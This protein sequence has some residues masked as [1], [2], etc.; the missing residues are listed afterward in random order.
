MSQEITIRVH[1]AMGIVP[2]SAKQSWEEYLRNAPPLQQL[3]TYEWYDSWARTCGTC[4]PWTGRVRVLEALSETGQTLALLPLAFRREKGLTFLC[5][6]GNY[7]PL[8]GFLCLPE[9]AETVCRA[10]V[11][12]LINECHD[13]SALRFGPFDT[14]TAER[15]ALVEE[16]RRAPL[17]CLEIPRARTIVAENIPD[18]FEE[19]VRLQL[20]HG[21]AKDIRYFER[22]LRREGD[23]DIRHFH[24]PQEPDITALLESCSEIERNSWLPSARGNV[25]F[26]TDTDRSFWR[27]VIARSLSP[28][29]Q[30]DAWVLYFNNKPVSFS[31]A[32]TVKPYRYMVA[33][34]FDETFKRYSIG[35]I[36]NFRA[37]EDACQS[38]V[39]FVDFAPGDLHYKSRFGGKEK[40]LRMDVLAFRHSLAGLSLA[41]V[42]GCLHRLRNLLGK[43]APKWMP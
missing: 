9:R 21:I 26:Q 1:D 12:T 43:R 40:D 34:Q 25:R 3:F 24:D 2:L 32:I 15:L 38:C 11:R 18:S 10:L 6:A 8:R 39:S 22:R 13:W 42:I 41:G 37:F 23:V 28:R 5:L 31:V 7:Q 33:N 17:R 20:G 14:A 36:L 19:Y 27:E 30:F 4:P 35:W 16:L 29:G